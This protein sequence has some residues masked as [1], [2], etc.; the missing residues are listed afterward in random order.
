[1]AY[2]CMINEVKLVKVNAI[3]KDILYLGESVGV[4]VGELVGVVVGELVGVTVGNLV[5]VTV[6]N[7]VGDLEGDLV[8]VVVG[9]SVLTITTFLIR[10]PP[11]SDMYILP[12]LSKRAYDGP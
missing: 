8:G 12:A 10:F 11:Q 5:G 6:G 2:N 4:V 3:V 9:I 1:M 7:L